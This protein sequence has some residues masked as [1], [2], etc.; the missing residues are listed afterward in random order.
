VSEIEAL[1]TSALPCDRMWIAE[2][3]RRAASEELEDQETFGRCGG[4]TMHGP[5]ARLA[6]SLAEHVERLG[7]K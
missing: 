3:L 2:T 1:L 5:R 7:A 6:S 4:H